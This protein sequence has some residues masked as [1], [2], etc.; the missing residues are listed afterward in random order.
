MI[1][2]ER[3]VRY[4]LNVLVEFVENVRS[5]LHHLEQG[6]HYHA[7]LPNFKIQ[8]SAS[9]SSGGDSTRQ[10]TVLLEIS[11][12]SRTLWR[13]RS[14]HPT[15]QAGMRINII[16]H[17]SL[18]VSML[19]VIQYLLS[20]SLSCFVCFRLSSVSSICISVKSRLLH[21][22]AGDYTL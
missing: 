13:S 2:L 12:V 4:A 19:V 18:K 5:K 7:L 21:E 15:C 11:A 20:P 22:N 1:P 6:T 3:F 14:Q 16:Q 10:H 8:D 9:T 17:G